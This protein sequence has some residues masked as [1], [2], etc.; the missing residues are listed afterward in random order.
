MKEGF[1]NIP[2]Q[3]CVNQLKSCSGLIVLG[4]YHNNTECNRGRCKRNQ[5]TVDKQRTDSFGHCD[6]TDRDVFWVNRLAILDF[7]PLEIR[8]KS[9]LLRKNRERRISKTR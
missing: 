4:V 6:I 3:E 1:L 5:L 2:D 8:L 7:V 9:T